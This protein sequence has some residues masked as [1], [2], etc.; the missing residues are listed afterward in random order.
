MTPRLVELIR[1][2]ERL[3][4]RADMQRAALADF[5]LRWRAPFSLLDRGMAAVRSIKSHP[6]LALAAIAGL[7]LLRPRSMAKW[8]GRSWVL[9]RFWR[10]SRIT[11]WFRKYR[12][13]AADSGQHSS[14][15][16]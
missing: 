3:L 15:S 13:S 11:Q 4:M 12:Q 8:A 2:R 5:G 6:V 7:A 1:H 10:S 16:C 14:R 9:W